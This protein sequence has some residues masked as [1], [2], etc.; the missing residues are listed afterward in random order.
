MR[1]NGDGYHNALAETIDGLHKAGSFD[2]SAPWKT[3]AA[4]ELATPEWAAWFNNHH[5]LEP[6]GYTPPA[7]VEANHL[8]QIAN[9]ATAFTAWLSPTGVCQTR[10]GSI[11]FRRAH[12]LMP[13]LV[14]ARSNASVVLKIWLIPV[15]VAH[16]SP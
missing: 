7:E 13:K 11:W 10:G 16:G 14:V 12:Q 6:S 1:S 2:R 15:P 5:L 8:R 9:E 3:K 4:V